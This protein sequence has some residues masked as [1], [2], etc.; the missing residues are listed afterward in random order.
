M[1]L[2]AHVSCKTCSVINFKEMK[3]LAP[4]LTLFTVLVI[5]TTASS[6][7][8]QVVYAQECGRY[9]TDICCST[10]PNKCPVGL[11]CSED[12]DPSD[13]REGLS[14][15]KCVKPDQ[16]CNKLGDVCCQNLNDRYCEGGLRCSAKSLTCVESCNEVNDDC[17]YKAAGAYCEQNIY[18][19]L[20]CDTSDN[21]CRVIKRCETDTEGTCMSATECFNERGTNLG[22][23]DCITPSD[24][25]RVCCYIPSPEEPPPP[26]EGSYDTSGPGQAGE[27]IEGLFCD[28]DNTEINT[29][30]GCIPINDTNRL[31]GFFLR[32]TIGI[33]G[34]IAFLLILY[35]GVQIVTSGGDP[36]KVK[37]AKQ[38]LTAAV[39]GLLMLVFSVVILEIIGVDILKLPGFGP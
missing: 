11:V 15:P 1:L 31:V 30:I 10:G 2:K 37:G 16:S 21:K 24:S 18:Q 33:G 20:T 23:Y 17:C 34:G 13:P 3:K 7:Q 22:T 26:P 14:P 4:L 28:K 25:S 38:L 27:V 19:N 36:E 12:L 29:A 32:F 9:E 39:S 35:S 5:V 8:P 6:S